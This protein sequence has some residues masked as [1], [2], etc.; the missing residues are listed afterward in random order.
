[1]K[2]KEYKKLIEDIKEFIFIRQMRG[3]FLYKKQKHYKELTKKSTNIFNKIINILAEE[4]KDLMMEYEDLSSQMSE[5]QYEEQYKKGFKDCA[6][7]LKI[8][9][10]E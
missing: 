7:I 2:K 10:I 9:F 3:N 1:M 8:I 5:I 6:N 4:N